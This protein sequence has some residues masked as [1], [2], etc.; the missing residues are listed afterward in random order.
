[1]VSDAFVSNGS[2][3]VT[4][5]PSSHEAVDGGD[6]QSV[7]NNESKAVQDYILEIVPSVAWAGVFDDPVVVVMIGDIG[8]VTEMV[9]VIWNMG[10]VN[11]ADDTGKRRPDT[12][13]WKQAQGEIDG[14]DENEKGQEQLLSSVVGENPVDEQQ[15]MLQT[16]ALNRG[17]NDSGAEQNP[18]PWVH[19]LPVEECYE[20]NSD[21]QQK[22]DDL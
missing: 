1:M 11:V 20:R 22:Q 17:K 10:Q 5:C 14:E 4:I 3:F 16:E 12:I 2:F 9:I 18:S 15:G 7:E 13:F 6:E 8:T 21:V 19:Y